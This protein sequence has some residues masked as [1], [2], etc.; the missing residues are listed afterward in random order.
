VKYVLFY[1]SADDVLSKPPAHFP[2]H[3][4]RPQDFHGGGVSFR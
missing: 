3:Q 2:A 1:E 4:A